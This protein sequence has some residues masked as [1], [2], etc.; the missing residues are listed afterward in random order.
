LLRDVGRLFGESGLADARVAC[1]QDQIA[2][3]RDEG[4]NDHTNLANMTLAAD[5]RSPSR[6]QG[7]S[8]IVLREL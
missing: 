4:L 2:S 5:Q 7:S 1:H 8:W 6:A 3:P